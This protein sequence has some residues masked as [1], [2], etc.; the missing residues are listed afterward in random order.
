MNMSYLCIM[1]K[2]HMLF[3]LHVVIELGNGKPLTLCMWKWILKL[4][5]LRALELSC[6]ECLWC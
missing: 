2:D 4:C 3:L 1:L 5:S 6:Y